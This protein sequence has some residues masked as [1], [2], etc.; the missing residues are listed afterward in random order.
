MSLR[1]KIVAAAVLA[2]AVALGGYFGNSIYQTRN[3]A[4]QAIAETEKAIGQL[5]AGISLIR[6]SVKEFDF[7]LHPD[8]KRHAQEEIRDSES[9]LDFLKEELAKARGD[10][11]FWRFERARLR[12]SPDHG[13]ERWRRKD[14]PIHVA[15]SEESD[16]RVVLDDFVDKIN[17]RNRNVNL[18]WDLYSTLICPPCRVDGQSELPEAL[19]QIP[20]SYRENVPVLTPQLEKQLKKLPQELNNRMGADL[21][22]FRPVLEHILLKG[23]NERVKSKAQ[24]LYDAAFK[25]YMA[26]AGE[27]EKLKAIPGGEYR[28]E[29]HDGKFTSE[30]H[31]QIYNAQ[32]DVLSL[33]RDGDY[34]LADLSKYSKELHEQYYTYVSELGYEKDPLLELIDWRTREN[35]KS[36]NNPG[37]REIIERIRSKYKVSG[38]PE[39]SEML[40][41]CYSYTLTKVTPSGSTSQEHYSIGTTPSREHT[42]GFLW[43]WKRLHYDKKDIIRNVPMNEVNPRFERE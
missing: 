36:A 42:P 3:R 34:S 7:V 27:Y 12:V 41:N 10:F 28:K 8:E 29:K 43:E 20:K 35:P 14:V 33:R 11:D 31:K 30:Q 4:G 13:P 39:I 17:L 1:K 5:E 38:Q 9:K 19:A 37:V 25:N 32:V 40:K 16:M 15:K 18:A 26:A 2:S 6:D 22:L 23:G 21:I 24:G